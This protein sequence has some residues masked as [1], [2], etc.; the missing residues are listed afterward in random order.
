[1]IRNQGDNKGCLSLG[2]YIEDL[3]KIEE[4]EDY[5]FD[6]RYKVA[7]DGYSIFDSFL[8]KETIL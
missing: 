7:L 6:F 2:F 1:M 3:T 8:K 4:I 5:L